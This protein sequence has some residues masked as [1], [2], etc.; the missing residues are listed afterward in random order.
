MI[1]VQGVIQKKGLRIFPVIKNEPFS[2]SSVD[3][4]CEASSMT[5][6]CHRLHEVIGLRWQWHWRVRYKKLKSSPYPLRFAYFIVW[7]NSSVSINRKWGDGNSSQ[8]TLKE[9][10]HHAITHFSGIFLITPKLLTNLCEPHWKHA[11]CESV[12]DARKIDAV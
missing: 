9:L 6:C 7:H 11:N 8:K 3:D 12:V 10:Q 1:Q 4:K 2:L 5:Q